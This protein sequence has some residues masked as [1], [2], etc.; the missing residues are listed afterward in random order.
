[1]PTRSAG[2]R[3]L[4]VSRRR[5]VRNLRIRE[6][7]R[8]LMRSS[9]Q[10]LAKGEAA[11]VKTAVGAAVSALDRAVRSGVVKAG[12]AARHKSRLMLSFNKLG[13]K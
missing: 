7:L 10:A 3:D 9:R 5:A 4:R 13:K 2:F 8:F 6:Q 1:M 12:F 11:A